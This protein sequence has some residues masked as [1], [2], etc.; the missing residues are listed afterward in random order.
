M[1]DSDSKVHHSIYRTVTEKIIAAIKAGADKFEM[2]W[3][4]ADSSVSM[5]VNALTEAQ[6]RGINVLSLWVD[7][8]QK[9]YPA[10][11]WASYQ[12]WQKLGAQV[13]RGER[14]S[15]IV[16]YKQLASNT[17]ES[18]QEVPGLAFVARASRVF[19]VAQVEGWTL[20]S[21]PPQ[22]EFDRHNQTE[23]FV[24]ATGARVRHGFNIAKYRRD[25]D[26]IEMPSPGWFVGTNTSSPLQ[27]YYAILLHELTHWSGAPHRLAREFGRRFGDQAYAMEELTAELGAAF[28]CSLL[29]IANEPRPDHASY[30]ASWLKVLREDHQAIFTAANRAQLA[31]EYLAHFA[32]EAGTIQ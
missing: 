8:M 26:D 32:Y 3:H 4:S 14:G 9:G 31:T 20:P 23:S 13:R 30:V 2:P 27:S 10:G 7:A 5:P 24:A 17:S 1:H 19:N 6:Y 12:Q 16:F 15:T 29:G 18:G 22:P 21:L 25:L 28:L 11:I